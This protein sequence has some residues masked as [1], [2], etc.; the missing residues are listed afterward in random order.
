MNKIIKYRFW[1]IFRKI[2]GMEKIGD[3]GQKGKLGTDCDP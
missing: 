3:K 1:G 2:E